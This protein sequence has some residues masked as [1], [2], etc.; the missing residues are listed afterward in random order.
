[1]HTHTPADVEPGRGA[2]IRRDLPDTPHAISAENTLAA[3]ASSA[4]GLSAADA[5]SR[6]VRYGVNRLPE[7]RR[8]NLALR[9]LRHF[10]NVL[11][12]VLVGSAIITAALGYVADTFVILLVVVAN[13]TIGFIQE[14]RAER[15]MTAIRQMI[16]PHSAVLRNGQRSSVDSDTIVP[17][18]VV[19]LEPGDKVPADLRLLDVAGLRIVEA[20]L[21]GEAIPVEKGVTLVPPQ[22]A[23]SER[24]C[25]AFS[26][27]EVAG[28]TG[29]GVV[30]ATGSHTQIG[31]ISGLLSAVEAPLT[32][33]IRQMNEFGSWITLVILGLA[34]VLLT[35][36]HFAS[37]LPF[38][39]VFMAVVGLSVA[40]IPEGL[41]AVLTITL[42]VGVRRMARRNVIVRRLPVI[43]TLGSVSVICSDKTGTLTRNEMMVGSVTIMGHSYTITGDGYAPAGH[44]RLGNAQVPTHESQLLV[45]IARAAV[46]CNDAALHYHAG[47]WRVEG[48]PM[49]GALRAFAG[50]V[51]HKGTQLWSTWTRTDEIPFDVHARFMATLHHDHSGHAEI[52]V[53]GAPERIL[54]L[55]TQQRRADGEDVPLTTEYWL[56][57]VDA[58]A[59]Q[60][61]RVLALAVRQVGQDHIVLDVDDLEGKLTLLGLVG[62]IDPPRN[63]AIDA[64]RECQLASIRVK[65]ITGDHPATAVAIA[66]QIGLLNPD[67]MMTGTSIEKMNDAELASVVEDVDVFART[68]PEHKLRLVQAL[69]S[70]G[71]VVAMTGDGFNDAPALKRADAG[72]AMGHR[73]SEV[74]KE[75]AQIVLA[76]DNFVSIVAAV[77]EGRTVYDNIMKVISWTLPTNA[78][79]ML[80]IV[81]ALMLGLAFPVTA[82]QIL[83]VNLV[84]A[85]TLGLALAFEPAAKNVM[86]R[87]PRASDRSL[88]SRELVWHIFLVSALFLAAIFG[89][90][91]FA[92]RRGSTVELAQTLSLNMLVLL[93]VCHLFFVRNAYGPLFSVSALRGSVVAWICVLAVLCAQI[94][95]TY[96]PA[97]QRIFGT[98]SLSLSDLA[99]IG[100]IAILFLSALIFDRTLRRMVVRTIGGRSV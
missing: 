26:G 83:W 22:T 24:S 72:I 47:G 3:L 12:Y 98:V 77:R 93:E 29:R 15:S 11:I 17:G 62:L 27:T 69:Q 2:A 80:T 52:H 74:A 73:G 43:E 61:Q 54:A 100:V 59:D 1:M 10:H 65:M 18:D 66:R 6:L 44:V 76:D 16:S 37:H 92:I 4:T 49:E 38:V 55:C 48:D 30:V 20:V 35:Y 58:I 84:T 34:S 75:A 8:Q 96:L 63:E 51:D 88:L 14:D 42:A 46:L 70:R 67:K 36:G 97:F 87:P 89:I 33:L 41:P 94:L 25:M 31:R 32:P 57:M 60:G 28:G 45:E 95:I 86:T 91:D 56:R 64:I 81:A 53:K 19:L 13:A 99:M 78:G 68:S 71:L 21:T 40:A 82:I 9:I 79:E 50:K 23:L 39:E 85:V 90:F 5:A 7:P